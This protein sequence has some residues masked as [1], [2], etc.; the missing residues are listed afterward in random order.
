MATK[1]K[2]ELLI[3]GV[4]PYKPKKNEKYMGDAQIAHFNEIRPLILLVKS[5]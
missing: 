5:L 1:K 2:P 4:K 3:H